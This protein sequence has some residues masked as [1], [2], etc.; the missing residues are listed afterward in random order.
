[1]VS[2]KIIQ[3][4]NGVN[5]S[6]EI[7][8]MC[9]NYISVSCFING[10]TLLRANLIKT[11]NENNLDELLIKKRSSLVENVLSCYYVISQPHIQTYS[12]I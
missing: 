7:V 3:D 2:Y 10:Y 11:T 5:D 8:L 12:I 1:M 4:M 6:I 9:L